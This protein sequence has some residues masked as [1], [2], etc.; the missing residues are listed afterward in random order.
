MNESHHSHDPFINDVREALLGVVSPEA[1]HSTLVRL[2]GRWHETV[3]APHRSSLATVRRS[4]M[5]RLRPR[6][7]AGALVLASI[8]TLTGVT[9]AVAQS[10]AVRSLF[11]SDTPSADRMEAFAI[12]G[13]PSGIERPDASRVPAVVQQQLDALYAVDDDLHSNPGNLDTTG[14]PP[15]MTERFG[16]LAPATDTQT[17]LAD[18]WAGRKVGVYARSTSKGNVCYVNYV[19][20][21]GESASGCFASYFDLDAPIAV[22]GTL[23]TSGEGASDVVLFGLAADEITGVTVHLEDGTTSDAL[24]GTNAFYWDDKTSSSTPK[25]LEAHLSN[26]KSVIRPLDTQPAPIDANSSGLL[27]P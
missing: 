23:K 25:E 17:L 20:G 19:E 4:T 10:E 15:S 7:R 11:T 13:K 22:N 3:N 6:S 18:E 14:L 1:E 2:R 27:R 12:S 21:S 8:L 16:T 24:I 5:N 26:G 9:A